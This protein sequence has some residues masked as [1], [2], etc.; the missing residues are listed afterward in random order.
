MGEPVVDDGPIRVLLSRISGPEL[1]Q[2]DDQVARSHHA[3]A[4]RC[5]L[6]REDLV[7]HFGAGRP[8]VI[9]N[10]LETQYVR[11]E[12]ERPVHVRDGNGDVICS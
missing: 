10:F 2:L 8:R 1:E 6:D 3:A 12:F 11:I 4:G 9:Q 5:S 7:G